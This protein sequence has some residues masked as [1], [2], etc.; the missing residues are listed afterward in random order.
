MLEVNDEIRNK[1]IDSLKRELESLPDAFHG[2]LFVGSKLI[3]TYSKH[4]SNS[5]SSQSI[6]SNLYAVYGK[7]SGNTASSGNIPDLFVS[8]IFLFIS[9]FMA[10]FHP[11]ESIF[12]LYISYFFS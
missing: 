10:S 6:Y 11:P 12:L 8:D 2:M 7:S 4:N 5:S 1:C 3:C 9:Y